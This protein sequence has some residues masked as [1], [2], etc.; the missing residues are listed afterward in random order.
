MGLV[1]AVYAVVDQNT[2]SVT[3]AINQYYVIDNGASLVT[4]T[5]PA[6]MAQGA[7]FK[8]IGNSSGGWTIAQLAG[9]SIKIGNVATTVGVGGSLSSSNAGDCI[10]VM[11]IVANT[12]YRVLSVVGN[13][14]VV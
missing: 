14:T 10:E 9:Q 6:T 2:S 7:V 12:T 1:N 13:P 8:V 4:L 5:L 11:C 3:I